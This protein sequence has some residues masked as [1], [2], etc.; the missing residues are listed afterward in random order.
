MK[1]I[2]LQIVGVGELAWSS[3]RL[4]FG[5][6]VT[7]LYGDN[8]SGK[9]PIV[10]SIAFALG[11]DV[12][13]HL[14]ILERADRVVLE[15]QVDG[16][17]YVIT[18]RIKSKFDVTVQNHAGDVAEFISE[19]EF[20]RF[21]L[22]L[23]GLEDPVLTT[24][25]DLSTHIY[26]P[27]LL[28]LFYLDQ[29][30]GYA[31]D[32][33]TT[34]KFI[35]NQYAEAMRLVFGLAPKNSC[36]KRR[37]R[38]ELKD[39][40]EYLD[41]AVVRLEKQ[42]EE[43]T[44]DL[45]GAPRRS[46]VE[47]ESD[48]ELAKTALEELRETQGG[49]QQIDVALENRIAQLQQQS[50]SLLREKSELEAR[51]RGFSQIRHEIE[52]EADTLS[53]N[54]EARRVF[55]LFDAICANSGCGLF[56]RSS[57]TY[58][59]SLLYLKD[60]IKDLERT[61]GSHQRRLS[62]LS[63]Q[64]IRLRNEISVAQAERERASTKSTVGSL[65]EVVSELT[66]RVIHL[67]RSKQ[68][69][70]ELSKVESAYVEKLDERA[71]TQAHLTEMEGGGSAADLNLLKVRNAIAERIRFWLGIL[72]SS[73]V[74]LDVHVDNDFNVTFGGQKITAYN[75][76]TMTRVVL[77]IRTAAF[78]LIC[79]RDGS[80]PRFFILDTPRQ[81]DIARADL[82]TYI[83]QLQVLGSE[84]HAQI[85]L[86]TTNHRYDLGMSD[87]E[88]VPDFPGENHPMFLGSHASTDALVHS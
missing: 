41:R 86:S 4:V 83:E 60:Q 79:R 84:H 70:I 80:A 20:S 67:R 11:Y 19:R 62:I 59:K 18:R 5:H 3:R 63:E 49:V 66:E 52:V 85:V 27:Q 46:A 16:N 15:V 47:I 74:S 65:V 42:I 76:S 35:K 13:Y 1:L 58:G 9:T 51:V 30:H 33:Y 38:S 48:L 54:E 26:S 22:A 44:E 8:G 34:S 21:L 55:S 25:R 17:P 29:N 23:W 40:L 87:V 28:P 81:Q 71:R 72:S 50:N 64:L 53:L 43:L 14:D 10:Q 39:K 36:D 68:I 7:Q 73:N 78:E 69:E 88:W 6:R 24:V 2:A 82:A 56:L 31:V 37:T 32:Y 57:E 75:G 77:A 45:L 61:N 12:E